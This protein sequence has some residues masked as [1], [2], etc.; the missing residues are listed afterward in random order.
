MMWSAVASE[1]GAPIAQTVQAV[2]VETENEVGFVEHGLGCGFMAK[3]ILYDVGIGQP[4]QKVGI[5]IGHDYVNLLAQ[6][7]EIFG[8]G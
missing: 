7:H 8:P 1:T 4:T 3:V 2:E 5:G 6:R